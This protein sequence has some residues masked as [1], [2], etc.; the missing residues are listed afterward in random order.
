MQNLFNKIQLIQESLLDYPR[1]GLDLQV[2]DKQP[3]GIYKLR[4]TVAAKIYKVMQQHPTVNIQEL[5]DQ[6]HI[7]GSITTNQYTED[8]DIDVHIIPKTPWTEKD[9]KEVRKWFEK[10][11]TDLDAFIGQHPI[12]ISIQFNPLQDYRSEGVYDLL[13]NAWIKGPRIVPPD[14]DP[15][16]DYSGILKGMQDSFKE[17]DMLLGELKRDTIDFDTLHKAMVNMSKAQRQK[18]L[19]LAKAKLQEIE[20]D[21][22]K[23][24]DLRK[25]WIDA[26]SIEM[27]E[28]SPDELLKD[29]KLA[30]DWNDANAAF[31]FLAKYQ[32]LKIIGDLNELMQD[33]EIETE[34]VVKLKSMLGIK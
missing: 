4:D 2:W 20:A 24:Y 17:A 11:Q 29:V 27:P 34:D 8:T 33:D 26:R 7:V 10:H 28:K 1:A 22:Q 21:I 14:Y 15:M 31:K 23:L 5:A 9:A 3:N 25:I 6:I 16:Q 12:E 30:K 32:Y 19:Q 13:T 18:F